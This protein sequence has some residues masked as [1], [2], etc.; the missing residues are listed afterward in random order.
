MRPAF[1]LAARQ[2]VSTLVIPANEGSLK[3]LQR[4]FF[5]INSLDFFSHQL[6]FASKQKIAAIPIVSK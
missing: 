4:G 3:K 5:K 1:S 2:V 6:V